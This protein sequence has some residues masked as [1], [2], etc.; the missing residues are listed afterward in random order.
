MRASTLAS[1]VQR[2]ARV[3]TQRAI[4]RWTG[5]TAALLALALTAAPVHG[6]APAQ[7]A[8]M[9]PPPS[10]ATVVAAVLPAVV[11]I[12]AVPPPGGVGPDDEEDEDMPRARAIGAGVIVDPAGVV[13]TNAHVVRGVA[14]E[15]LTSDGRRYRP[16]RTALDGRSDL[17]I[18]VIGDGTQ[19]FPSA[20]FGDSDA[21]RVGDWVVAMGASFGQEPSVTAGII[22]ARARAEDAGLPDRDYL[23]TTAVMEAGNSGGPLV[24]LE[25][26]VIGINLVALLEGTGIAF[27]IPSSTARHVVAELV[28]HGRVTR[29]ELGMITQPVTAELAR[30]FGL[31]ETAGLLVA[32]VVRGGPAA[33]AG[34]R[35]G[36]VVRGLEHETIRTRADLARALRP[37]TPGR[38]VALLVRRRG[39][40]EET[41][42]VTL[43]RE[44]DR[45]VTSL[46]GLRVTALGLEVRGVTPELGVVVTRVDREGAA[47]AGGL[48]PGDVVREVD[49][50]AVSGMREFAGLADRLRPG[51]TVAFLVQR[52]PVGLYVAVVV[53]TPE[54]AAR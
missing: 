27:T 35:P 37:L 31:A 24:S 46:P 39:G 48:R 22:S 10:F 8:A 53:A 49:H 44:D 17:A 29:A 14:V 38:T 9:A 11:T 47:G 41:V 15:I 33:Q 52:G 26:E 42:R 2:H 4:G 1:R 25:G 7:G 21:L 23:Q 20:R 51:Q 3:T 54:H 18:V 19:R 12:V 40:G 16:R 32:D 30:A 6:A 36:D 34:V 13:V 43:G 50:T 28:A 5:V 45:L